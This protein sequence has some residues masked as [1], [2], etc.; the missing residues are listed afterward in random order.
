[1]KRLLLALCVSVLGACATVQHGPMQGIVVD[2][3]PQN[4]LV[5]TQDCGVTSTR[6]T[7]TPAT[8]WVSRRA[9]HCMLVFTA[10]DF[11]TE[12]VT[13][14][15]SVAEE[16]VQNV[17]V[18][19]EVWSDTDDA[20]AGFFLGGLLAGAGFAVD[21]STGAMFQQSPSRVFVQLHSR[22]EQLES[23]QGSLAPP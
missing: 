23:Q 7:R 12:R 22:E 6:E 14:E 17:D 19:N 3:D 2:S 16:F 10:P 13:L 9:D 18:A 4:V 15:R 11:W 21:A 5:R 20:V 8:V 1:M